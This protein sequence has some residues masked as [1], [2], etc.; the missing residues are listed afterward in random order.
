MQATF[1]SVISKVFCHD[2]VR[3]L[4]G[5]LVV[6]AAYKFMVLQNVPTGDK[7]GGNVASAVWLEPI[8]YIL[9]GQALH[10]LAIH[11]Q[12]VFTRGNDADM[13]VFRHGCNVMTHCGTQVR[14]VS[15][16]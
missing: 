2:L 11:V 8:F 9:E 13:G 3:K 5:L 16:A 1:K 15:E 4:L 6:Y 14:I 10:G 7:I 12:R